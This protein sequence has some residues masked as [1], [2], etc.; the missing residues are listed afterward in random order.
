ML[1]PL[2]LLKIETSPQPAGRK[3][4]STFHHTASPFLEDDEDKQESASEKG[5]NF[6]EVLEPTPSDATHDNILQSPPSLEFHQALDEMTGPSGH[7]LDYRPSYEEV[8]SE[9]PASRPTLFRKNKSSVSLR[10]HPEHTVLLASPDPDSGPSLVTPMSSTFMSFASRRNQNPL[11][12]QRANVPS[13]GQSSF[14]SQQ[15]GG[16]I[17]LFDTSLS[18]APPPTSPRSSNLSPF[19]TGLE[20]CPEAH[21]LRPFW[22]MRALSQTITHP[23]GGFLTSKLFVPR[24]AWQTRGVK[25]RLVED[26]VANCDLLTAALGRLA[27]V[28]TYDADAVA[29]ELQSFEEVMERVQAVLAKKL[30][31]DVGVHG[32]NGMFKDASAATA[33]TA[34]GNPHGPDGAPADKAAKSNSGKSYLT[35]WRKLRNKSSGTPLSTNSSQAS[36][37]SAGKEQHL[38]PSVPMTSFVPVERRGNKREVRNLVFEGPN[39][40]YMGSLARLFDGVQVLGKSSSPSSSPH[41]HYH[42]ITSSPSAQ[43][44]RQTACACRP[45]GRPW[46]SLR[47]AGKRPPRTPVSLVYLQILHARHKTP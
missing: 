42:H 22:L 39:K 26:K 5:E 18:A 28:D 29:D 19:P 47:S 41:H 12:S 14:D 32:V 35:S 3:R 37:K 38:M 7:T 8:G 27:G 40:E 33:S 45:P 30:G 20:P 43:R 23:R 36:A 9:Q 4:A 13:F 6:G 21:L 24:E 25:L 11:T 17:Y 15:G 44:H 10:D 46:F 1:P 16:G 31:S 34:M 2:S